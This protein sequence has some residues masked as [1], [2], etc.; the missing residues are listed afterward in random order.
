M[1]KELC[2]ICKGTLGRALEVEEKKTMLEDKES[3]QA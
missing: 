1:E 3:H 2:G